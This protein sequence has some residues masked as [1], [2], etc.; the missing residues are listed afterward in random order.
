M[1]CARSV[2]STWQ[3]AG[4]WSLAGRA[5]LSAMLSGGHCSIEQLELIQTTQHTSEIGAR[6]ERDL[7]ERERITHLYRCYTYGPSFFTSLCIYFFYFVF[8]YLDICILLLL[9]Y[10][11]CKIFKCHCLLPM[12]IKLFWMQFNWERNIFCYIACLS[13]LFLLWYLQK[14]YINIHI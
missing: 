7:V 4:V 11:I 12:A 14:I 1:S 6:S 13:Q 9:L 3:H 10:F 8:I 5:P 2:S